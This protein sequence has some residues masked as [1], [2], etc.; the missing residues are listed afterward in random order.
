ML[1]QSEQ[2]TLLEA[3]SAFMFELSH[4]TEFDANTKIKLIGLYKRVLSLDFIVS[5]MFMKNV[6]YKMKVLTESLES[7]Q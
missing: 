3:R 1:S 5:L 7:A 6:M 2:W 4:S